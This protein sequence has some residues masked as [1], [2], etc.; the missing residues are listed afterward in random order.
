[1]FTPGPSSTGI[2]PASEAV[3]LQIGS[4]TVTIPAGSFHKV[5]SGANAPYAYEGTINGVK[6]GAV[7]TPL[8]GGRYD[9]AAAG[10]PVNLTGAANPVTVTLTIGNDSGTA[11]VKAVRVR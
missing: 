7:I 10:S 1:M 8:S 3:T 9:F 4:Y 6:T 2:H 5:G 11:Q